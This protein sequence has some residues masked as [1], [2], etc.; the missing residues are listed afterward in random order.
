SD[1]SCCL[2]MISSFLLPAARRSVTTAARSVLDD[3][4]EASWLLRWLGGSNA[5]AA[6]LAVAQAQLQ[7]AGAA[8]AGQRHVLVL[9]STCH[10]QQGQ[11]TTNTYSTGNNKNRPTK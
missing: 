3:V 1:V 2:L 9:D 4:R 6:M 8:A 11:Y 10:S 5:P 7:A